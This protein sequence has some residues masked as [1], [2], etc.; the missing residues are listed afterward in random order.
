[1]RNTNE[2]ISEF[3]KVKRGYIGG[4]I[5]LKKSCNREKV[6]YDAMELWEDVK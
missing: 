6:D 3:K 4:N 2:D 1:M 5:R